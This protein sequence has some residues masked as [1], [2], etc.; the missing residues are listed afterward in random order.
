MT[1]SP[2]NDPGVKT[3]PAANEPGVVEV[4]VNKDEDTDSRNKTLYGRVAELT[5]KNKALAESLTKI[6]EDRAKVR[7]AALKKQGEFETLYK[8]AE[9]KTEATA[10]ERDDYKKKWDGHVKTQ[11]EAVDALMDAIKIDETD[12]KMAMQFDDLDLR[13]AFVE[14]IAGKDISTST[15]T[16]RT[17]NMLKDGK[18]KPL[19]EM[20]DQEKRDTHDAR[21]SQYLP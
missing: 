21:I 12:R 17:A 6:E 19:S 5:A 8:E 15:D 3:D 20:T 10:S 2:A 14:R 11:T 16:R 1:D 7:A 4:P 18:L 9:A 13:K